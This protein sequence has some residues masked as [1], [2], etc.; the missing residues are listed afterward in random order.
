MAC[1]NRQAWDSGGALDI[2]LVHAEDGSV[3]STDWHVVFDSKLVEEAV[4]T[5]INGTAADGFAM[6]VEG[7]LKPACFAGDGARRVPPAE[8]L[9]AAVSSGLIRPGHNEVAYEFGSCRVQAALFLWEEATPCVV[10]DIDG[11][12]T[13]DDV[14]GQLGA[15]FD[16]PVIHAGICEFACNLDARG[17]NV[18]F[19]TARCMLGAA[20]ID[21][22]RRFLFDVALDDS[23]GYKLPPGPVF[24]TVHTSTLLALK[25]ELGGTASGAYKLSILQRIGSL[26]PPASAAPLADAALDTEA[27]CTQSDSLLGEPHSSPLGGLHAGFGNRSKDA[28]AYTGAGIAAAHT[29]I[30]DNRSTILQWR[31][32]D[33]FGTTGGGAKGC[34]EGGGNG[35]RAQCNGSSCN[36]SSCNASS[37]NGSSW[38]SYSA[39]LG[40]LD[41]FFPRVSAMERF[42]QVMALHAATAARARPARDSGR[43]YHLGGASAPSACPPAS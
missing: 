23:S 43:A 4:T 12:V 1:L 2:V 34:G 10:F 42:Q 37:C 41:H 3:G 39:L 18:L 33:G 38:R 27:G 20:G 22:T 11:T 25:E 21:R 36:G 13:T 17:Y 35:T 28:V 7:P 32:G 14:S 30:I 6:W 15:L 8:A 9:R 31:Q 40:D 29:F 19:L 5:V 16:I 26:F 24:T